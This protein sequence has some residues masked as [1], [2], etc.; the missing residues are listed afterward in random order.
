[1]L[2]DFYIPRLSNYRKTA[3][4][5][6]HFGVKFYTEV[7]ILLKNGVKKRRQ[8]TESKNGVKK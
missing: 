8:K 1:M 7:W 6:N 4:Q 2:A 3:V 5:K